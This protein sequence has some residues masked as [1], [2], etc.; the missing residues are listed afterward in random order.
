MFTVYDAQSR[1]HRIKYTVMT[2]MTDRVYLVANMD[3]L[4]RCTN[5]ARSTL[6]RRTIKTRY[7]CAVACSLR[8][9]LEQLQSTVVGA[10]YPRPTNGKQMQPYKQG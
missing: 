5:E 8:V 7:L 1:G 6:D 4:I 2:M 3:Y 10:T 9:R